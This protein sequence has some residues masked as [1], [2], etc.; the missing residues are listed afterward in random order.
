M[1]TFI[2]TV[3]ANI[4]LAA[5]ASAG[6]A[7][8]VAGF[9]ANYGLI[10][11]GLALSSNAQKNAKRKAREQYNAAQVDRIANISSTVAPR[12][13]VLGRV[14]K[15][16]SVFYRASTGSNK[17]T[18]VMLV[19]LAGHEI[20]AV[21]SIYLNDQL[22][23][24]DGNGNVQ[25]APY[26]NPQSITDSVMADGSGNATLPQT[27]IAGSVYAYTGTV[28]GPDGDV[29]NVPAVVSGLTVTTSP[30]ASVV[31]QYASSGSN[32]NIRAVLGSDDQAADAALIALMPSAWTAA[33]R[34]RGVAYLVCT[35]Q[36]SETSFPNGLP[37]VSAVIRGAKV[38]DPRENRLLYSRQFENAAWT[39]VACSLTAANAVANWDG[40]ITADH[41]TSSGD[42]FLWQ[43]VAVQSSTAYTFSVWLAAPS[44]ISVA[45]IARTWDPGFVTYVDTVENFSITTTLQR[46]DITATTRVGDD[47]LQLFIGGFGTFSSG[48]QLYIGE[49][50]VVA[51]THLKANVTT[52]TAA[53]VPVTAWSNNPALLLRH[54]YQHASF[55]KSAVSPE[56]DDR[57]IAAA[58]ACDTLT[59]YIVGGVTENRRL[60]RAALTVPF[61]AAARDVMDDLA[62]SMGGSW[63]FAG[64]QLY[65]RAGV[66]TA[67]VLA[68]ADADLAVIERNGASES[69]RPIS[70]SVHR[71]RAQKFNTV[72][73]TMWDLAQDYK[74]VTLT[75][76]TSSALVTRDSATLAQA[77][78]YSA[79]GYAPQALH[80]AGIMLRDARDPLTVVLP[81]KT[82]AYPVE[83]F[84]N[85]TLTLSRYGWSAKPFQVMA[86]EWTQDGRLQLTLKETA[87]SIYTR[88][89]AFS[90]QGGAPNTSIPSP[91]YVPPVGP[92]SIASGTA[93]LVR[94]ADGS[95]KSRMRVSWPAINDASVSNGGSVEIQYRDALSTAAWTS[96]QIAGN[97]SQALITE[98]QDSVHYLVRA[99]ARNRLAIG[100]WS[101]QVQH[102]VL[103][104][105][106]A[107]PDVDS[108]A[109]NGLVLTWPPVDAIDLAGYR[110]R[111]IAGSTANWAGGFLLHEGIITDPPY[112]LTASLGGLYTYMVVAVDTSG[113]ESAM[114]ASISATSAYTL[115]GNT[116][117]SWPQAP[118]F[119][120]TKVA[121]T[122]SGGLLVADS[123][124]TLFW[125]ADSNL[126]WSGDSSL[127]WGATSYSAMVY[128]FGIGPSS[129]GLLV[130]ESEIAGD[131][132]SVDMRRGSVSSFWSSDAAAFWTSDSASFWSPITAAWAPWPGALEVVAGEYIELRVTTSSGATQG[133]IT[134]LT[135]YLDVPTVED[136][137]D[138]AVVSSSGTRLP[139]G[140]TF[141]AIKNIQLT[142][143]QDGGSAVTA[144]W[145]DKLATGPL[146]QALDIS[147][148]PV[149]STVDAYIKGY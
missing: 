91:W 117:E 8:A 97:E 86:R 36:Y 139:L 99:R 84:D 141:R 126:H 13:L 68:L 11:G 77:V 123:T 107:P 69:Q 118:L 113:N 70:I 112:T 53:I 63:A 15:G 100:D 38:Y 22:V 39:K 71:E 26:A 72:N 60:Y 145:V 35:F 6:T 65:L 9:A 82:K 16:G 19:A 34:A 61:G 17:A 124:G 94:Q 10:L 109:V 3:V 80:V 75:P 7:L 125:G 40:T 50:Q 28:A 27:P 45:L 29:V 58:N 83:V 101:V 85:V 20:D 54:V 104:K 78:T 105:T 62:Q 47:N 43:T 147:G 88:D 59:D 33:H 64:G 51:G 41:F 135:P 31:Y 136:Y 2:G 129:P 116:L 12:E 18:F 134:T 121:G 142:V 66:W 1:P 30:N 21:E 137:V 119:E 56:E 37:T 55:G 92:I 143:Q 46:F 111:A 144:R 87:E 52:T 149:A 128:T 44:P 106:E 130:L 76:L 81:F 120:G 98:V 138:N 89:A 131:V 110:L 5:G 127:Y 96:V 102:Q 140:K 74:Q 4:A 14:R 115:A 25:N 57:I 132:V 67:P 79:I 23:T 146:V 133:V 48:E 24:L 114:P 90:A 32:A 42:G 148:N 103:G 95:V 49:A 93:E 122:V 73:V 108:L